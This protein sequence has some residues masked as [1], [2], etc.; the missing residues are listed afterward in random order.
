MIN[1][2]IALFTVVIL[3]ILIYFNNTSL[4]VS[5]YEI[6]S[7]KIPHEFNKYKII[8]LSDLHS[9]NYGKNNAKLI[10]KIEKEN[11]EII[12]I[13][14]DMVNKYDVKFDVFLNLM[15]YLSKKYK[16]YYI[17]GNHEKKLAKRNLNFIINRLERYKVTVISNQRIKV[18]KNKEHINIYG[19]DIPLPYY[20]IQNKPLDIGKFINKGLNQ[21]NTNEYNVLLAHNPL[22][23]DE[24]A[25]YNVDITLSGHIHGGMI[26]LPFIGALLSPERKF[27]PKFSAGLYEVNNKKL[28]VHRGLG[29]SRYGIRIFNTPEIICINFIKM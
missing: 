1:Y 27:F 16:I 7:D 26:R 19:L 24:Y 29:H 21:C 17:L 6:L 5:K 2:F 28:I 20:K 22:Y 15:D 12:V 8:Q 14:G 4:K 11:P 10:K 18:F 25:K 13:T 23:F 3:S 9:C